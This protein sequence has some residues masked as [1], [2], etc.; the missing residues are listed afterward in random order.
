MVV[1]KLVIELA[2]DPT[3]VTP[4][5]PKATAPVKAVAPVKEKSKIVA[6]VQ[7]EDKRPESNFWRILGIIGLILLIGL[8]LFGL[9]RLFGGEANNSAATDTNAN[10]PVVVPAAENELA[11]LAYWSS[12]TETDRWPD[13]KQ[14]NIIACHNDPD[15]NGNAS[16]VFLIG[17]N[18]KTSDLKLT[19]YNGYTGVWNDQVKSQIITEIQ[20]SVRPHIPG[21]TLTEV[22]IL[23]VQ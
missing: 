9:F 22:E 8:A 17:D 5:A 21:F 16:V 6:P 1:K 12:A 4:V 19:Y 11:H 20:D 14:F 18:I 3:V 13:M 23:H 2:G 7:A 15:A 10:P